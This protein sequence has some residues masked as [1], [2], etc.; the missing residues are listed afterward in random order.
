M[1]IM[2]VS[3]PWHAL[4]CP[5][6][7]LGVLRASLLRAAP[8]H[9]VSE[10]YANLKL[11]DFLGEESSGRLGPRAYTDVAEN[12]FLHGVGEWIFSG[13]LYGAEEWRVAEYTDY[14]SQRSVDAGPATEM[15]RYAPRF[16]RNLT[17][18]IVAAAPEVV[19]FTTT[20]MQNVPSL[21]AARLLKRRAP[22]IKIIF[23][24]GNCDGP[25]GPALHRNFPFIDFVLSGEGERSFPMTIA[26]LEGTQRLEDVPGLSWR[27]DG[28]QR[29]N[30]AASAPV[31][32]SEVAAPEFAS[33]FTQLSTSAMRHYVEPKLVLEA[34]RGCWW[35]E[36]HQCTFC[37]LNGS[38]MK[39]RSK[40]P[41]VFWEELASMVERHGVLDVIMVDNIMDMNY[42][43]TLLPRI[44][45]AGWDLR[46]HYEVKSNL[47][48]QHVA[49]LRSAG[50]A[51]IQPGIES[52][53]TR[54][55]E[56]MQK[57][58]TGPQNV[59]LL[60]DCEDD[61]LTVSW[62]YLY[63]FPGEQDLDY[64]SVVDQFPALVHL[65]PPSGA[66]RIALERFSPN[67]ERARALFGS[68]APAEC[69]SYIYDLTTAELAD[70]VY[71]YD[72]PD[73][74]IVDAREVELQQ[75]VADWQERHGPSYLKAHRAE[76]VVYIDDG[77]VG[78]P[79]RRHVI[80]DPRQAA[81]YV[82][83]ADDSTPD[84]IVRQVAA[85]GQSATVGD[86]ATWLRLWKVAGLVF[87]DGGR[88]VALATS[89]ESMSVRLAAA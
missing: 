13:A 75:A 49:A 47:R 41:D 73:G 63:G 53:S 69:Y 55:L 80:D 50:I 62:N 5:S 54:V 15:Q 19:A 71:L 66:T 33:Y 17:D 70:M 79:P 44:T 64:K 36:K 67:F 56:L 65:Q 34:A 7:S 72:C 61:N 27:D 60:R 74:G 23:G 29:V 87:E 6:L 38:M 18:E 14:L 57:G 40:S 86:V 11:A 83:L 82:A 81:A 37:G 48:R 28:Q 12:G 58:V 35:G 31:P 52:L 21:A 4:D 45:G 77:R 46:I 26:A 43:K 1:R 51:H 25:Q 10:L 84:G 30:A 22:Q 39:F 88:W 9:E 3:M 2:L 78:W 76:D 8:W 59:Q 89:A 24:G 42:F 16:I 85:A 20:F 32:I 68:I